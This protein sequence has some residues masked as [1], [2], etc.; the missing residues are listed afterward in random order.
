MRKYLF[1]QEWSNTTRSDIQSQPFVVNLK[2]SNID[3]FIRQWCKFKSMRCPVM[4]SA[5]KRCSIRCFYL[6]LFVGGLMSSL[7]CLCLLAHSGF[8]HTLC[9][10]FAL[11]FVFVLCTLCWQYL[12]IVRDWFPLSLTFI[13][14]SLAVDNSG[15]HVRRVLR[16]LHV[17]QYV[18]L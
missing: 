11:F 3:T 8:Q 16:S 13:W 4:I 12:W 7:R 9:C 2:L 15:F 14:D 17:K 5:W 10:V 18:V 1:K 6:Q